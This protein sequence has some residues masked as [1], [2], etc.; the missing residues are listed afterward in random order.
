MFGILIQYDYVGDEGEWMAAC[1]AFVAA[2]DAD[3]DL[4]GKFSYR[5][6]KAPDGVG[7]VHVGRWEAKETLAHLQAQDFFQTFAE[8]IGEFSGGKRTAT[9]LELAAG[10]V[11]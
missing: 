9:P 1:E 6:S 11:A 3:P 7:R 4:T 2:I 10:T 5:I 8:K